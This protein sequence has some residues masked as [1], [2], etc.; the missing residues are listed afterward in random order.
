MSNL[1]GEILLRLAKAAGALVLAAL[2]YWIVLSF[3]GASA[4]WELALLCWLSASAFILLV[5][6]S[7]L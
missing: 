7:P 2:L 6:E 1:V 4:S 3:L 5:E